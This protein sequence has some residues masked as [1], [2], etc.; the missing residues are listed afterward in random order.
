MDNVPM[1]TAGQPEERTTPSSDQSDEL[2]TVV[3]ALVVN[4]VVAAIKAV[5]GIIGSSAAL[6]SESAHSV[7]DSTTELFLITAV[8]RSRRPPN[9][10]HPFGY[11]KE[12]YFWSLLA[13]IA[14][15]GLGAGY[16]VYEGVSTITAGESGA[17]APIVG[18]IVIGLC[19]AAET[20]S[21]VQASRRVRRESERTDTEVTKYV[22]DPDDPT[23]K[24]VLLEDAAA[25]I[26]L[27]LALCGLVLRQITG[28]A[29]WDG[30]AALAIGA[31]LVGI[32]Y[33]LART[34]V[35]LLIGKQANPQM[36]ADIEECL[37]DQP[38]VGAVV[39]VITM[40]IGTGKVLVCAR[41]DYRHTLSSDEAERATVRLHEVLAERFPDI[42]RMYLEPVPHPV[43]QDAASP[44]RVA[45]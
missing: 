5:A 43:P 29:L 1:S 12:R 10:R 45:P 39:D 4:L 8:R 24:S 42:E 13:A 7:A 38:E 6:L 21:L 17:G 35:G 28:Q 34:N 31:L 36:V 23:V 44:D 33:E 37:L 3:I 22:R 30:V 18:Y 14:I 9:R 2:R 15:F 26:G 27:G 25:L 20:V 41:L 16:S 32:A 40:M 19:A 11:G